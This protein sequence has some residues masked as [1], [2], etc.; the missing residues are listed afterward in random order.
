MFIIVSPGDFVFTLIFYLFWLVAVYQIIRVRTSRRLVGLIVL[1]MIV[2]LYTFGK[3]F[4][5][6]SSFTPNYFP[7]VGL[8][9]SIYYLTFP[10]RRNRFVTALS[11]LFIVAIIVA[12]FI[13]SF[14]IF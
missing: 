7:P 4:F 10:Q 3:L 9:G 11:I 12:Y 1:T 13:S 5:P 14:G 8:V 2:V 6:H